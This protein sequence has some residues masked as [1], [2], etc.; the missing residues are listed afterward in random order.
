[1][2]HGALL[3]ATVGAV[4][5]AT[6]GHVVKGI[7][8]GALAGIGGAASYYG[9]A[10]LMDRRTNGVAIPSA[11]MVTW[12]LLAA[13]EGRWLR[14]PQ[15]RDWAAVAARGLTAVVLGG[16]AFHLVMQILW[17]PPPAGGR[18]YLVQFMAWTFAWAPGLLSLSLDR[19][20]RSAGPTDGGSSRR[21]AGI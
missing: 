17:G 2:V 18:N 8:I 14:A 16:A 3:L 15:R 9:M 10:A 12:L 1:V 6:S 5:G 11:W 19:Q 21:E 7:P 4:L 13:L 20:S